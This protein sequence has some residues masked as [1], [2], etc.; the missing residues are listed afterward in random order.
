M[1]L[2][3]KRAYLIAT[4]AAFVVL[5][6]ITLICCNKDSILIVVYS[7]EYF[8]KYDCSFENE[9]SLFGYILY[10]RFKLYFLWWLLS[11]IDKCAKA[12]FIALATIGA[13]LG[14]VLGA[15]LINFGFMGLLIFIVLILPH[16]FLY[17]CGI[18]MITNYCRGYQMMINAKI[19]I[20]MY[21]V[22]SLIA[23]CLLETFVTTWII[24][25]LLK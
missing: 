11:K 1:R 3:S 24:G 8:S 4:I 18:Y 5:L 10:G 14:V 6:V 2:D 13:C 22:L 21:I 23:G 15:L 17:F 25:S 19:K 7:Q 12:Y 9:K 20:F 16:G